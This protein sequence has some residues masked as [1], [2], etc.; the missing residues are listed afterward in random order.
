MEFINLSDRKILVTGASSGIGQA[1]A[2]LLS[3][4]GASVVLC[5]RS[6]ERLQKTIDKM[7]A[8][9]RHIVVP[10]DVRDFEHYDE[11]FSKATEDGIKLTGMVHCAGIARITPL[12]GLNRDSLNEIFDV[13]Y[14]AFMCLTAKYAKKKYSNGGCIVGVSAINAHYPQ[15]CM[16][17]YAASKAAVEASVRTWALELVKQ[18]I[19]INCVI[20]GA[21]KTPMVE[22]IEKETWRE[23]ENRQIL[24]A[25][26]PEQIADV[27]AFLV[28][29]RSSGM[30][31]RNMYADGGFLGQ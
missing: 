9:K 3:Q 21:V 26:K 16:S 6:E 27:I 25:E 23:I 1:T 30:T 20:P 10:F 4:L 12:R 29:S 31:G 5:A 18:G 7:E 8:P 28:S 24:G 2:V 19:R 11:L 14:H 15:K 17:V 22:F 13:N